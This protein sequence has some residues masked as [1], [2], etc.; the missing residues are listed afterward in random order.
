[1]GFVHSWILLYQGPYIAVS[2]SKRVPPAEGFGAAQYKTSGHE[3]WCE[4]RHLRF[5]TNTPGKRQFWL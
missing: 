2:A 4:M 5:G 3:G 1:M